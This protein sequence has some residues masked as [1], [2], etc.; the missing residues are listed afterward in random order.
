MNRWKSFF[1]HITRTRIS[2]ILD[3]FHILCGQKWTE[4]SEALNTNYNNWTNPPRKACATCMSV[5][6]TEHLIFL[7]FFFFP[8]FHF[9]SPFFMY[10]ILSFFLLFLFYLSSSL[11][12]FSS[13]PSYSSHCLHS[14]IWKFQSLDRERTYVFTEGT[15]NS[16]E[17][18]SKL[19]GKSTQMPVFSQDRKATHCNSD[20]VL[21]ETRSDFS[22]CT[23]DGDQSRH[24]QWPHQIPVR[25]H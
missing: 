20:P 13:L 15:Q 4:T 23:P 6:A 9:S 5:K 10:F 19:Q 8:G 25:F 1:L 18:S 22:V 16:L 12:I 17:A 24:N 2:L 7:F 14:S 21:P 11:S 3:C